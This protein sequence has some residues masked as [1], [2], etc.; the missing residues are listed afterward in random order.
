MPVDD[1]GQILELLIRAEIFEQVLQSQYPDTK[2]F[3]L[4]G[5]PALIPLLDTWCIAR[6]IEACSH[7]RI[8]TLVSRAFFLQD[9]LDAADKFLGADDP[10]QFRPALE[11]ASKDAAHSAVMSLVLSAGETP[12]AA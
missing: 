4:E 11:K 5:N 10:E 12:T 2:R 7:R 1:R 6:S 9:L 8:L 3:S